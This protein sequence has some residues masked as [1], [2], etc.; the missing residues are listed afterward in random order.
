MPPGCY[1][2]EVE[3][4]AEIR[5]AIHCCS[6]TAWLIRYSDGRLSF[7]AKSGPFG[8]TTDWSDSPTSLSL[9][10]LTES[11]FRSSEPPLPRMYPV[12]S[13]RNLEFAAN[14]L[15][16]QCVSLSNLLANAS[17]TTF[18]FG[19]SVPC[20]SYGQVSYA[21]P[22]VQGAMSINRPVPIMERSSPPRFCTCDAWPYSEKTS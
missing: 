20:V 14:F 18:K 7:T 13:Q 3:Y 19:A 16:L 12:F 8:A 6:D 1:N 4:F 2:H 11:P 21:N 17:F 15:T 5:V 9:K 22:W 10:S